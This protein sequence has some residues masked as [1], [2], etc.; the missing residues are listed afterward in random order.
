MVG[1]ARLLH[2]AQEAE[3]TIGHGDM[4]LVVMVVFWVQS[5]IADTGGRRIWKERL[6]F[7]PCN[8]T[9]H[10]NTEVNQSLSSGP[11]NS[12]TSGTELYY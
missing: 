2:Q 6:T 9:L 7:K 1:P 5:S 10:I 12:Q 11:L 4:E 8:I 3:G